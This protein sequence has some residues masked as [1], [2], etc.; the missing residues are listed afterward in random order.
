MRQ[1]LAARRAGQVWLVGMQ[2]FTSLAVL[3]VQFGPLLATD[4]S[5]ALSVVGAGTFKVFRVADPAGLKPLTA[6]LGRHSFQNF[7]CHLWLADG[8]QH[9]L[10][11]WPTASCCSS[12][13]CQ[14][15]DL[16]IAARCW[17]D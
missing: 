15:T 6:A 8:A 12:G 4:G 11:S 9:T 16:Q 13:V 2:R 5:T 1:R 14:V 17:S 10:S 7:T 3:Q